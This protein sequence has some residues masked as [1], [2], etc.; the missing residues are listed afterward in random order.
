M[1][2][3]ESGEIPYLGRA[4]LIIIIGTGSIMLWKVPPL[5]SEDKIGLEH[6][7]ESRAEVVRTLP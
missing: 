6:Q 3:V 2:D 5:T 7:S 4:T 1:K